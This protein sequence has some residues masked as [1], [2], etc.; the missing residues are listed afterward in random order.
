MLFE[1]IEGTEP[2]SKKEIERIGRQIGELH[3][4]MEFFAYG[5]INRSKYGYI[6]AYTSYYGR[7]GI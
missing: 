2:E 1:Y 7:N 5:L 3:N 4:I 6:D